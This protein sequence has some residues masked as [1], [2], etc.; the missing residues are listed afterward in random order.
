MEQKKVLIVHIYKTTNGNYRF[1]T[2]VAESDQEVDTKVHPL[3][4]GV[5]T[6]A[7]GVDRLSALFPKHRPGKNGSYEDLSAFL[8]T[9]D[10]KTVSLFLFPATSATE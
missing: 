8:S 1:E 2:G 10:C 3:L 6:M 5:P 4:A 9:C 7:I